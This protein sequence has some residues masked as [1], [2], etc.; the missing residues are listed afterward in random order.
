M[1]PKKKTTPSSDPY[2][3]PLFLQVI[4]DVERKRKRMMA[5]MKGDDDD[6][7]DVFRITRVVTENP[8]GTRSARNVFYDPNDEYADDDDDDDDEIS[9]PSSRSS[10]SRKSSSKS[11]T[12]RA[13]TTSSSSRAS[14][15]SSSSN[16]SSALS[17][18]MG[19]STSRSNSN[20]PAVVPPEDVGIYTEYGY[21]STREA[22]DEQITSTRAYRALYQVKAV[23]T[24]PTTKN[25]VYREFVISATILFKNLNELLCLL[26]GWSTVENYH[27]TYEKDGETKQILKRAG[28]NSQGVS[29]TKFCQVCPY[30]GDSCVWYPNATTQVSLTV[31]VINLDGQV[32][33]VPRC[34]GLNG[35]I[36]LDTGK[37]GTLNETET[38]IDR[39]NSKLKG[40]RFAANSASNNTKKKGIKM[41]VPRDTTQSEIN[42]IAN[43]VYRSKLFTP[44][45]TK[46]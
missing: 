13:A 20:A 35:K 33:S 42:Q 29:S 8:D 40:K 31:D 32:E 6:D 1:P 16:L 46:F 9:I 28:K 14:T 45:R 27:F 2:D 12:S 39:V 10:S 36:D 37:Q 23:I 17:A 5:R 15:A 25:V 38:N 26:F 4:A 7:G 19:G 11:S 24:S 3:D 34:V 21:Q 43:N 41:L 30:P 44:D 22:L 18:I